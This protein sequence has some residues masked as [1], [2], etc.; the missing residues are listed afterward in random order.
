MRPA[1]VVLNAKSPL[2]NTPAWVALLEH[3]ERVK[4]VHMVE[5][6]DQDP[7]RFKKYSIQFND[8]LLDYSKNRVTD[9]TMKLLFSLAEQAGVEKWRDRMFSGEKINNTEGRAVLHTALRNRSGKPVFVDDENVMPLVETELE[10][11][12]VFSEKVRNGQWIGYAGLPITNVVNIGIGGSDLGPHMVC[13][14]LEPYSHKSLRVHFVSNVD[15][16]HIDQILSQLRPETTLFIVASKTF[17]T[18]ETLT[19]ANTAKKWFLEGAG[20]VTEGDIAKHFVAV[21][22]NEK[23]VE[24]FG[25]DPVNMFR[26]WDWVGGRYSLWSA[27]GLASAIYV[28]MDNFIEML[29]GAHEMDNHFQEQPLDQNIPVILAMLGIW[30]GNFFHAESSAVLPY[31]HNLRMLPA[32]LEQ[33]DMESNGKSVDR[34]GRQAT[35]STGKIIWGAEGINGQHA[36]YQLLHQGTRLIPTDFIASIQS[37]GNHKE[38][39]DILASNFLAQTEALMKGRTMEKTREQLKEADIELH[40]AEKRLPHMIFS[41]NQPSNSIVIKKLTPKALGSLLAMYEH[42][43]F[44]QGIVWNLNSYDQWGVELGK[45]LAKNILEELEDGEDLYEHDSSTQ[46]LLD[47]FRKNSR[48]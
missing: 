45:K 22:T 33:A 3:F 4:K 42:K 39:C 6:F 5:L 1:R 27:V 10:K 11:M 23:E 14:A 18:Q 19:N 9:V 21:S 16:S 34:E 13:R 2:I 25:I 44:V 31:D 12:R 47:W 15:G 32:Y 24:K 46:G 43:I 30:Y 29:E 38:H 8:M 48:D 37:H 28:G 41:G 40:K 36:F 26:F 20:R 7:E 17:T 35:Y